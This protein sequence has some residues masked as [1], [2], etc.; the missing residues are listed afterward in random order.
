MRIR[1]QLGGICGSDLNVISLG[2]S[3]STSP[4]SSFP[5]VLGH[6][7]VGEV[8]EVGARRDEGEASASA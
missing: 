4:F 1:T 6:E 3:P 8:I 7:N 2:A 5:F